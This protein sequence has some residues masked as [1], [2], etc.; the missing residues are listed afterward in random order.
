MFQISLRFRLDKPELPKDTDRLIVSFFKASIQQYRPE[1]FQKL[2][3]K[4]RSVIKTYTFS[5]Y[6]P[7]AVFEKGVI[8]LTKPEFTVF[9]SD[10]DEGELLHFYNA[11]KRM[12]WI[13]YPMSQNSMTLELL[14][15]QKRNVIT[16]REVVIKMQSSLIVREHDPNENK[17]TYFSVGQPGF[18]EAFVRNTEVMLDKLGVD[19]STDGF[20][21]APIKAKKVVVDVFS[22]KTDASVGVFKLCGDPELLNFLYLTGL[23]VRRGAGHGKFEIL[24]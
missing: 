20:Y 6:L 19:M 10:A 4:D 21:I 13:A 3:N 11:F 22:R 24:C 23:G 7:G 9:F 16:D 2:Y 15:I 18:E 8:K 1:L 17:D 12:K 14:R 5:L